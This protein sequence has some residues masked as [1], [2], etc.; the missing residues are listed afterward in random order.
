MNKELI[1]KAG[2]II[3]EIKPEK[4]GFC[5]LALIDSE[6]YPTI[7]TITPAKADGINWITFD[8][9]LGSNKANRIKKCDKASVCFNSSSPLY[10]ITL[11]GTIEIL[12]DENT[13]KE[14]WYEG[15]GDHFKGPED[16][17]FCVLKFK[18]KRY[19][20]FLDNEEIS[21]MI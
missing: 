13:K 5:S 15:M 17:N 19:N 9:G 11:V 7:S 18:T 8:T 16:P 6:G 12:T 1:E 2:K 4:I 3:K 21:G 20:I 10:N 14:M